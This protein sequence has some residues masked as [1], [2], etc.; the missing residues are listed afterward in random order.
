VSAKCFYELVCDTLGVLKLGFDRVS[1]YSFL[2][3]DVLEFECDTL[4]AVVAAKLS[5]VVKENVY[6]EELK[7]YVGTDV[8]ISAFVYE[9][10]THGFNVSYKGYN[11]FLPNGETLL[12]NPKFREMN[13]IV[14]TFQN[15]VISEIKNDF[16]F[17]SRKNF[18]RAELKIR[19]DA[20]LA[21]LYLGC[22][23]EGTVKEVVNYGLFVTY[24]YSE[25]LLHIRNLLSDFE[26]PNDR[27]SIKF[28][29]K[30]LDR[31]FK[32]GMK[33]EVEVD[34]I[35]DSRFSLRWNKESPLNRAK[36][37]L[38]EREFRILTES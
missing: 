29:G 10:K 6:F 28:Y 9:A 15:F 16:V 21:S 12:D 20:E 22:V 31:V 7:A 26:K 23:F 14:N 3:G 27:V 4:D 19:Q 2:V 5:F 18:L 24:K 8:C 35:T 34:E 38:L 17:V 36:N 32:K 11:C 13:D 37:T 25:G 30:A 33:L 1:P